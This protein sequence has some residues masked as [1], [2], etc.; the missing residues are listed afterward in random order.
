MRNSS[1]PFCHVD[2]V[3]NVFILLQ[4]LTDGHREDLKVKGFTVVN[5]VLTDPECDRYIAEYKKWLKQFKDGEWP[6]SKMSLINQYNT[7]NFETTWKIRM[8][9]K[10]IFA[11]LWKTDKLLSSVDAIA[12]GRP[13]EDGEEE[14]ES[15]GQHWLHTDQSARRKGL[16]AYQGGVYLETTDEDDWTFHLMEGSHKYLDEFYKFNKKQAF[17]SAINEYYHLRDEDY[18]WFTAKGCKTIR[19]PV[20]KGGMVLWDSRL[21]HANAKPLRNRQN[22]GRWRFTVFICMTPAI[23]ATK[24]DYEKR[25]MAYECA[26]MTSHWPTK[27]VRF[28]VSKSP[29]SFSDHPIEYPTKLP[30]N[31]KTEDAKL[32]WGYKRYNFDDG[33]PNGPDY[34]PQT[35]KMY[36][37]DISEDVPLTQEL[38]YSIPSLGLKHV[39]YAT[40]ISIVLLLVLKYVEQRIL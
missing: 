38:K 23:W 36:D 10:R 3:K 25:R 13:P 6:R 35:E 5:G 2:E 9:A 19:L 40:G 37:F 7:G 24:E 32:L 21:I 16:H 14:F 34:T 27:G 8:K 15:S 28:Y 20:P 26:C 18:E 30:Q 22:P 29:P 11:Q 33:Q 12:I 17:K 1:R 31:S 4:M 39:I